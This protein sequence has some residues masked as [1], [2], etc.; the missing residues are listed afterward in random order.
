MKRD[1][2]A[3]ALLVSVAGL[4]YAA[5][6]RIPISALADEVGPRGLPT[7]LAVL[8]ALVGIS[9]GARALLTGRVSPPA[10]PSDRAHN[11]ANPL[12][13]VGLL[14]VAATYLPLAWLF[15][16]V[17]ALVIVLAGVARYEGM[18]PSWRMAGVVGG[19]A[20][21]FW[22]LFSVVLGVPQPT[23]ILF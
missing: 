19:G 14:A 15:G 2:T 18:R 13:A 11:E 3:S 8:L 22:L 7:I 9:L 10:M 23:G 17:P 20:V 5:T 21:F 4:Y 12:R 6:V 1:L 16:Y